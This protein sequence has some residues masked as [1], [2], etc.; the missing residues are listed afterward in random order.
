MASSSVPVLASSE[1]GIG[2]LLRGIFA[3]VVGISES[4]FVPGVTF[5]EL[6]ADSLA[7]LEASQRVETKFDVKIPFRTLLEE[8]TT[9]ESV[10]RR[11]R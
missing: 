9:V 3:K 6:G 1:E 5:L 8:L 4:D 7:L 10:A 2:T 11:I